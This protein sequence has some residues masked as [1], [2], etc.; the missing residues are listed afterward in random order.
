MPVTAVLRYAAV[1]VPFA[2]DCEDE[3]FRRVLA[4]D[5]EALEDCAPGAAP[6]LT[7]RVARGLGEG[8][9]I[10]RNH[11]VLHAVSVADA[12]Y[13]IEKDLTLELQRRRQ[14]LCFF[15]AA[16]V[17]FDGHAY[18]LA[19]ESGNGKSTITWALLHHGF[20]YLTDEL[21]AVDVPALEVHG[22]PY[23][24]SLKAPPPS[25]F[26][27]PAVALVLDNLLHIPVRS[28][29]RGALRMPVPIAGVFLIEY[30]PG[31][32]HPFARPLSAAEAASRLYVCLLNA[33]AHPE[34]G[35]DAVLDLVSRVPVFAL[36][37]A[38]PESTCRLISG[39]V[40]GSVAIP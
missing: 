27:L 6:A 38:D 9:V 12:A 2:I 21:S 5:L 11:T 32:Q 16:A 31:R 4:Q 10:R 36:E 35:L 3:E 15:H 23:A 14:E 37:T 30:R 17:E 26:G 18:L 40:T 39:I 24:L 7:Y 29:P 13:A 19:A 22:F 28:M 1:G 20:R 34:H 8:F 25:P 33:L